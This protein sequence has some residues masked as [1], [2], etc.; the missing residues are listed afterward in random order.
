VLETSAMATSR[1]VRGG[2]WRQR[3]ID[4]RSGGPGNGAR[5]AAM[6]HGTVGFRRLGDCTHR[7]SFAL[8]PWSEGPLTDEMAERAAWRA[9][10]AWATPANKPAEA[11]GRPEE[12][13]MA[14]ESRRSG[15]DERVELV[16]P[17]PRQMERS[18]AER[19]PPA[20]DQ[21]ESKGE[22]NR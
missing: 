21:A 14:R 8:K 17:G 11:G 1:V 16:T 5:R 9:G 2:G 15:G 10:L 7:P 4:C 6:H 12:Q 19:S 18:G 20:T 22:V 3:A 13:P